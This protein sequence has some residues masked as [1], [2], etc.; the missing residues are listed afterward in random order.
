MIWQKLIVLLI[1]LALP[2]SSKAQTSDFESGD[3]EIALNKGEKAPY[4]GILIPP[5]DYTMKEKKLRRLEYI[6][7]KYY[8]ALMKK[9][10]GFWSF[11][12]GLAFAGGLILGFIAFSAQR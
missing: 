8:D 7:P 3:Y 11:S 5:D 2:I 12:T 6:E 4:Y 9:D 1:V 10:D